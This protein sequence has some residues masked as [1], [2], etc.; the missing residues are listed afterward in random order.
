[1]KGRI[2]IAKR[3]CKFYFNDFRPITKL[4]ATDLDR[5]KYMYRA[6]TTAGAILCGFVSFRYRHAK[7]G[8]LETAGV[9]RENNLPLYILNDIMAGFFG[10]C[11]GQFISQDYIYKQRTYIIERQSKERQ[12]QWNERN[13]MPKNAPLLDEYPLHEY[14]Q[15]SDAYITDGRLNPQEEKDEAKQLQKQVDKYHDEYIEKLALKQ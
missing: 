13:N 3:F 11:C 10:F 4:E 15:V 1:M 7:F 6:F 9:T 2:V 14:V 12:M 8:A 5:A